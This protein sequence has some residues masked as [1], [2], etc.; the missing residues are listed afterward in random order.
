MKQVRL[1]SKYYSLPSH[2]RGRQAVRFL[3]TRLFCKCLNETRPKWKIIIYNIY[4]CRLMYSIIINWQNCYSDG[5]Y[6]IIVFDMGY[7]YDD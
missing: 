5:R 7:V 1:R 4:L 3:L 2:I 6:A